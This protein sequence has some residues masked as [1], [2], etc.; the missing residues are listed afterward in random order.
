MVKS[1]PR[2]YL[3]AIRRRYR[4]ACKKDKKPILNGF[5]PIVAI[6]AN[7]PFVS[8]PCPRSRI[9]KLGAQSAYDSTALLM[10]IKR[11]WV[12]TSQMCSKKFKAAILLWLPR[13]LPRLRTSNK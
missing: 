7:T 6:T 1:T 2:E 8:W 5:A 3:E 10:A 13:K 11:I 4:K 9:K 12:A